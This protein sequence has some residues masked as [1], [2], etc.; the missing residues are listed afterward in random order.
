MSSQELSPNPGVSKPIGALST[1][2][3]K[4]NFQVPLRW[5]AGGVGGE[6]REKQKREDS[7]SAE[8]GRTTI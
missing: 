5:T 1:L 4:R 7:T 6:E 3:T 2:L 8:E